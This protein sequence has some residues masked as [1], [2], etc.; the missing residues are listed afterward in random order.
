M[1]I[2]CD[3]SP[4]YQPH[5]GV[6]ERCDEPAASKHTEVSAYLHKFNDVLTELVPKA[7]NYVHEISR[8]SM[9]ELISS[10]WKAESFRIPGGFTIAGSATP[11]ASLS[12]PSYI[13]A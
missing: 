1:S 9:H 7:E 6:K 5:Q 8:S 12:F 3:G 10:K 4:S 2:A 13:G 11:F